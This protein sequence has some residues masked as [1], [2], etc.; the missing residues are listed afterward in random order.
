MK[1]VAVLLMALMSVYAYAQNSRGSITGQVTDPTGAVIPNA[2][3]TVTSTDT[4]A[5]LHVVS[6]GRGFYTAPDLMPG[7]YALR[8]AAPGFKPVLRTGIDV[9][10]QQTVT[11]NIKLEVG[12]ASAEVTVSEAPPLIDI[13][14]ATTGQVISTEEVQDLPTNGRAPLGLAK[15]AYGV[16]TKAKHAQSTD[17][18]VSNQTEDDFSLGGGNSSSNELL[19]NGV[20]DM[21]DSDRYE[22]FS[23]E[24][25]A[26]NE[27][28]VDVFGAN[29]MYGDT[30][31]GTVNITTKGGTN[32]FHGSASWFYQGSGCSSQDGKTFTGRS[33]NGCSWMTALPYTTKVGGS[34]PPAEHEN[35]VG[36]TIGGPIWFPHLF[37]G[38]NKLFFFYAYEAY[39]GAQPPTQ[40]IG[41]VPTEAE[42]NGDFAG[43]LSTVSNPQLYNPYTASGT[44]SS[45]TRSPL[46][47]NCMG[48]DATA[49]SS[50]DCPSNAGLT[51][52]PIAQAYLKYIPLPNYTGPTTK[53]D[54]ENNFFSYVPTTQNYRSHMGR[55]DYNISS[56]DKLWGDAYRSKY[57]TDSSNVFHNDMSGT[58]T[59]QIFAGGLVEEVHTFSPTLFTDVRGGLSRFDNTNSETAAGISPSAFGFPGYMAQYSS[60]LDIPRIDFTDG[61]NP[62][63]FSTEPGSIEN[64]DTLQL[65]ADA[66]K[67]YRSHTFIAGIDFRAYKEST[68]NPGYA[69][70][71]FAFK[72]A[73][74]SPV[75]GSNTDA[76]PAFGSAYALFMLGIPSSGQYNIAPAFQYNSFLYAYFLQDDWK[77]ASNLTISMGVR[78][79]H[80]T[81][82]NESQNRMVVGW[83]A[84]TTNEATAAAVSN[85]QV[86]CTA[87]CSALLPTGSFQP[88]GGAIYATSS[89]RNPYHVAPVYVSPRLGIAW[90]PEALHEKGVIRLGYGIYDNPFGD[91]NFGQSYGFSQSTP[92]VTS[93]DQGMT[94]NTLADPFPTATTA[95]AVNPIIQPSGSSLGVNAELGN[96]MGFYSPVIKV[97]YSERTSLDV[98]YQIGN[99]MMIDLGYVENHQVHMP[100][101]NAISSIPLLPYLSHSSYYD[102]AA[103]NLLSGAAFKN[104]GPP[105]T[106]ITNP[107][108]GVAGVTGSLA[109]SS[110]IA[111]SSY[112]LSYPEYSG[113]TES[114]IP[115]ESSNYNALNARVY[116]AMGHGLT[117]NGVF[118]WSRLLGDFN[119]LNAGA[120]PTY[121]T[122]TSDHPFHFAGYG[123]Y[124]I[125]I[126]RH[127]QFFANDNRVLDGLIGG[128]Q[129][130][131]IYN[132]LSGYDLSW[133]NVVYTGNWHD[134]HNKQHSAA[135]RLGQP[136]FNTSVFDTRT[137]ENGG[138][139]CNNDPT[140]GKPLNPN[141]QPNSYN[142]RTFPQYVMRQDYTSEW[143]GTVQKDISG[144]ESVKIELRLD[145]FNLLNRPQYNT[146]TLSPTSSAFGTTNGVYSGSL[147]RL[148]QLGAHVVF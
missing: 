118:E 114:M 133:G 79:E 44:E 113:V 18:P 32:N 55:I 120:Q 54:G 37:N 15:I 127:R 16:V 57:L 106:Y 71:E 17:S 130:S 30:S 103:T 70:G 93:A 58:I 3:I 27:V 34:V 111:P 108:K 39:V 101:G 48:T 97:A 11:I 10:T 8:V 135:N 102:V 94:N 59:D 122:N 41:T 82:V 74:G 119:Q 19:L 23:P 12:S 72:S 110:Q 121:G 78:F 146:P 81:P 49:Y 52:S 46:P 100:W 104:G 43:L 36:G 7:G 51:L 1:R 143:D 90:A 86:D 89:N 85:Y 69:D 131:A 6:T 80:E 137:C 95:P 73:A 142:Y 76:A 40:T 31:G 2:S 117:M 124:E 84:N 4:G 128:W 50:S 145:A 139:S 136:V 141:I 56:K 132:F 87:A 148:F 138:T 107:F 21:Q 125:P 65:F 42:R 63:S 26:V 144:P 20:P 99:T 45:Y 112:L 109:T 77:A 88:T 129:V 62:L 5:V 33:G 60:A 38:R 14:D 105:T 9:Q 140:D 25:D 123:T 92:F 35:Q 47:N 24:L 22:A 91:S 68:L 13:A 96:S 116:K 75:T 61:S 126:G 83:N 115:G 67:I 64:T 98:Q 28:R 29:A 66:T 147:A 53:A 134:F